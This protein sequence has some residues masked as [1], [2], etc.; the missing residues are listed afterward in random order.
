M[1]DSLIY[2]IKWDLRNAQPYLHGT[3]LTQKQDG[4]ILFENELLP[5]GSVINEWTTHTDFQRDRREPQLPV[6]L[7]NHTYRVTVHGRNHPENTLMWKVDFYDVQDR[8][9]GFQVFDTKSGSFSV[10]KHTYSSTIQLIQ[11]GAKS[12]RFYALELAEAEENMFYGICH[13]NKALPVLNILVPRLRGTAAVIPGEFMEKV[14]PNVTSLSP[15]K[16]MYTEREQKQFMERL[17]S[18][19]EGVNFWS[20]GREG[21]D[22][23]KKYAS[24]IT[25]KEIRV[26]IFADE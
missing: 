11:A 20:K 12:V 5:P 14:F 15:V 2:I 26:R 19:F 1:T 21:S 17:T 18:G 8:K 22:M 3:I 9:L 10:P 16:L 23:A 7:E 24:L 25:N 6:L 13:R 4:S